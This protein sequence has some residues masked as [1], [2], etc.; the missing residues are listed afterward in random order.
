[1]ISLEQ[2]FHI[3][4]LSIW[5]GGAGSG[6]HG[7]NCG[8]PPGPGH[9]AGA[10]DMG[11]LLKPVKS[12]N[13]K[14]WNQ[15]TFGVG[16]TVK[17]LGRI[18]GIGGQPDQLTIKI[19]PHGSTEH[20]PVDHVFVTKTPEK[21]QVV[22]KPVPKSKTKTSYKTP[23]GDKITI[24]KPAGGAEKDK[25]IDSRRHSLRGKFKEVTNQVRVYQKPSETTQVFFAQRPGERDPLKGTS[26]FVYKKIGQDKGA[27][28]REVGTGD[29][30]HGYRTSY[31]FRYKNLGS[32]SKFL[33]RRYGIRQK[34]PRA[35]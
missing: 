34:L 10:G 26:V 25:G 15:K 1:M 24:V 2:A 21:P 11:R 16:T 7:S 19:M 30:G 9:E 4:D 3:A 12:W 8:R 14:T 33:Q 35:A 17:V 28:I 6:C 29:Y 20:V 27:K 5:A 18:K 23:S 32:A 31:E 22:P 13:E